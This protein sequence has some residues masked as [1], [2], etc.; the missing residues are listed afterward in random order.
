MLFEGT[1]FIFPGHKVGKAPV[2]VII[3]FSIA[4]FEVFCGV[5]ARQRRLASTCKRSRS[6]ALLRPVAAISVIAKGSMSAGQY[7]KKGVRESLIPPCG[8]TLISEKL[9]CEMRSVTWPRF[10]KTVRAL[11]V[12]PRTKFWT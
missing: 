5:G 10:V 4:K 12:V 2:V 6:K 8:D 11:L 9:Q 1:R 7:K 3:I